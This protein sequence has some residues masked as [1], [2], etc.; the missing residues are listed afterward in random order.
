MASGL[1]AVRISP[2]H[3]C[4]ALWFRPEVIRTVTWAGNPNKPVSVEKGQARLS[5]RKSFEAWKQTVELQSRPWTEAEIDS[6]T[7]LRN[8]LSG[9]VTGQIERARTA[10]CNARLTNTRWPK[11][12]RR[13][14]QGRRASSWPT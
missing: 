8:T 9:A 11:K 7:E 13:R 14:R 6:A 4:Y 10:E 3:G 12:P 2:E 5:P 1:L